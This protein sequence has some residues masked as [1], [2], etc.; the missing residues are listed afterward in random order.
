MSALGRFLAGREQS[1][2]ARRLFVGATIWSTLVLVIAGVFLSAV[3]RNAAERAFDDRLGVYLRALVADI[4]LSGDDAA[5]APGQLGE[6]QF[7]LTQ[8][9]W[10]WQITRL[11]GQ[12]PTIRASRSLFAARLPRLSELGVGPDATGLRRGSAEGPDGRQLRMLER[13]IDVGSDGQWLVQVAASREDVDLQVR[14]FILALTAAFIAL[15]VALVGATALQVRYGLRPLRRLQQQ[16]ASIRRG[17]SERIGGAFPPDLAPLAGE[18]NLLIASNREVLDRARTQVG[19]LAHA[20][21]TPLSVI[22]N[23]A[24]SERSQLAELVRAQTMLMRDQVTW[25]LDRA[26]AAARSTIIG[27][28]ADVEPTLA[29]LIRTFEKIY[30]DRGVDFTLA[31]AHGLRFRGERQ[32]LEEMVGNL[33]DNAGKWARRN[34]SLAAEPMPRTAEQAYLRLVVEDDGPGL[35]AER[36]AEAMTRGSRLDETKPG[37]G[38]GLSI[39]ADLAKIYGGSLSLEDAASGGLRAVL[40][41][42]AV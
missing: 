6:P 14:T 33:V 23:E 1:S 19:N 7:E 20:L 26:R 17:E 24:S 4:A 36:R 28:A 37:S 31:S 10:Y 32:D 22:A 5:S 25:H 35:P 27:A 8:S 21:K 40:I 16:V 39:V 41:L 3:Y 12:S 38:L 2:I 29:G 34:V 11:D 30:R 18:L 42:P 9:G 15:G 13:I